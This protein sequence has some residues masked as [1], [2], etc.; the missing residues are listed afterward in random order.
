MRSSSLVILGSGAVALS[1][2]RLS[3]DEIR[4]GFAL[5]QSKRAFKV[6]FEMAEGG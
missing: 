6:V 5:L 4:E 2:H 3:F 1:S